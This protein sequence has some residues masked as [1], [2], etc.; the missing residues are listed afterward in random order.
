MSVVNPFVIKR[1]IQMKLNHVKTDRSDARMICTYAA[2]QALVPWSPEASYIVECKRFQSAIG[3]Y[4]KQ[5]TALKNML[6]SLL[7]S[8]Q[9]SGKLIR[10]IKRQVKQLG[11]EITLLEHG[12]EQSI[13]GR[14]NQ[15]CIRG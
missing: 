10:S 7:T 3:L 14:T 2:D 9:A 1:F 8:G 6:H 15:G 5:R 13:K 12:M 11:K 4:L